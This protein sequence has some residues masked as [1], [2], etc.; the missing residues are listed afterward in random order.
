[1]G[2]SIIKM[3]QCRRDYKDVWTYSDRAKGYVCVQ[4]VLDGMYVKEIVDELNIQTV[5]LKSVELKTCFTCIHRFN[6]EGN[7]ECLCY[8]WLPINFDTRCEN[9]SAR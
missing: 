9:W 5:T 6:K 8:P 1:M 4:C 3:G 7:N 2:V